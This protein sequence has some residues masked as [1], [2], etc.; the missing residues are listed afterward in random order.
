MS[1]H[2]VI[3]RGWRNVLPEA[4]LRNAPR[5]E[6]LA[7]AARK[8]QSAIEPQRLPDRKKL[9]WKLIP[10]PLE[11]IIGSDLVIATLERENARLKRQIARRA[12]EMIGT[13]VAIT[14]RLFDGPA[15]IEESF[16]PEFQNDKYI[17]LTVHTSLGPKDAIAMEQRWIEEVETAMPGWEQL[18]LSIC[19]T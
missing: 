9:G 18:R 14:T 3:D 2:S 17:V 19:L 11:P 7:D 5:L 6:W 1:I 8:G 13:V 12:A 15:T 16:D 10:E 4:S